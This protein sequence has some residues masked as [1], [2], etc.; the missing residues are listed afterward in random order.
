MM[1]AEWEVWYYLVFYLVVMPIIFY[2]LNRL[3]K[4]NK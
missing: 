2:L 1:L 4:K 3:T